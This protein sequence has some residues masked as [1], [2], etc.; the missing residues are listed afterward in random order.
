MTPTLLIY[1]ILTTAHHWQFLA[2]EHVESRNFCEYLALD[3]NKAFSN[4]P[5]NVRI[6][7]AD[8]EEARH[9]QDRA[10]KRSRRASLNTPSRPSELRAAP[11]SRHQ[12]AGLEFPKSDQDAPRPES[13]A[14]SSSSGRSSGDRKS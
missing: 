5:G 9:D 12:P 4:T 10:A 6:I 3:V 2:V 14:S 8:D 1:F 11:V 13:L 7:C